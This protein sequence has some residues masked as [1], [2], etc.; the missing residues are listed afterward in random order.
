MFATAEENDKFG[1]NYEENRRKD[2][3]VNVYCSVL[4]HMDILEGVDFDIPKEKD[5]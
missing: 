2:A 3:E 5:L 1:K 4:Y